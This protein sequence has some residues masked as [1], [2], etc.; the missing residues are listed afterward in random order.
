MKFS[1]LLP[2]RNGGAYLEQAICSI[3]DQNYYDM[4]LVIS[5]NANTDITPQII[6]KYAALDLRVKAVRVGF[7]VSVTENWNNALRASTG[8]YIMMMGDDD[9]LLPGYF[10][11][12]ETLL[13]RHHQPDCVLH[14][15]YSF[16]APASI[17]DDL[18]SYYNESHFH[19]DPEFSEEHVIKRETRRRIVNDM[20]RFR[21]RIPLNMQTVLLRRATFK[22]CCGDLFT[23]PFP[24]HYA[25]NTLLLKAERWVFSPE[26]PVVVG[27]SP[28]SFGHFVYSNRQSDGLK[29]L[30]VDLNFVGRLPGNEL[31]NGMH[32]WLNA[33]REDNADMLV[34]VEVDRGA[35]VRRQFYSWCIQRKLGSIDTGAL[36]DNLRMLSFWDWVGLISSVVDKLA[37]QRLISNLFASGRR[38]HAQRHW[39]TLRPLSGVFNIQQFCNWIVVNRK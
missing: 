22:K 20:F 10:Q 12:M 25:L 15:A 2:T 35:Y 11:W 4:E 37:W 3:L 30:G 26:K 36:L 34:G 39:G 38:S 5:D 19:Y 23:S 6:R 17:G 18:M 9:S 31:I 16:V 27:I 13:D 7:P 33:L 1:V 8:D 28:K 21:V 14:N 24:D 29:Y 32:R